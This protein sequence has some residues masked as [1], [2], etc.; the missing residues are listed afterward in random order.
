MP[1]PPPPVLERGE[2]REGGVERGER[3]REGQPEREKSKGREEDLGAVLDCVVVAPRDA[4]AAVSS[5]LH[6]LCFCGCHRA[7]ETFRR[8]PGETAWSSPSL[9]SGLWHRSQKLHVS[10]TTTQPGHF[11]LGEAW[12]PKNVEMVRFVR[13]ATVTRGRRKSKRGDLVDVMKICHTI[14]H[15]VESG[16]QLAQIVERRA[17]RPSRRARRL[18]KHASDLLRWWLE[19][20]PWRPL[21]TVLLAPEAVPGRGGRCA[22]VKAVARNGSE[23]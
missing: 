21:G 14:Q 18:L 23:A 2:A 1:P 22:N 7:W 12:F 4:D 6:L 11:G 10:S 3:A 9:A 16:D 5:R 17:V 15:C 19:S 13:P 20:D 8:W